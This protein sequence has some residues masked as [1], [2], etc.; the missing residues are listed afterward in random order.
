MWSKEHYTPHGPEWR[1]LSSAAR[2]TDTRNP[3]TDASCQPMDPDRDRWE[4]VQR[5]GRHSARRVYI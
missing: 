1:L 4:R 3:V 5:Q 2:R